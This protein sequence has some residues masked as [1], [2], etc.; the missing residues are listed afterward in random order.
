MKTFCIIGD[1]RAFRTKSPVMF[2][3]VFERIGI[4]ASYIPLKV[5]PNQIG[6]AMQSLKTLNFDGANIT[7][8]HKSSVIPYMNILSEGANIIGAVNTIIRNGNEL[9]GYN[10]NA[11]GFMDTLEEHGFDVTGKRALVFGSGGGARAVIFILNWLRS[12][13]VEISGRTAHRVEN[14]IKKIGGTP[15]DLKT[16]GKIGSGAN[17]V[18]NT[19]P[20]CSQ[21]DSPEFT[22]FL[23]AQKFTDCELIV[24]LNYGRKNSIWENKAKE[25]GVPFIDGLGPLAHSA[26][27]T[28]LLW[29]RVDVDSS[30]FLKALE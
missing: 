8:P 29:T 19:T 23:D 21:D 4:S 17:I 24:D 7:I 11:I 9:K 5:L 28:L 13:S 22:Q 6:E 18:I 25:L 14:I 27:R 20:I 2:T 10:T 26:R 16:L 30:E 3:R 12:E 15:T 1:E